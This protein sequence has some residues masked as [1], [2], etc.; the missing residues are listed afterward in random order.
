[1]SNY[2]RAFRVVRAFRGWDQQGTAERIGISPSALSLIENGKRQPSLGL[3]DKL[4]IASCVSL[5]LIALLA[6]ND[7]EAAD[8]LKFLA[9]SG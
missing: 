3:I 5:P 6:S 7:D 8:A 9:G 1:M 2:A 4:A